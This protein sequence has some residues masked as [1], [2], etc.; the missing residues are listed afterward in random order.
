MGATDQ[1]H[2]DMTGKGRNELC[3]EQRKVWGRIFPDGCS[4]ALFAAL[5]KLI[6]RKY[7]DT[8]LLLVSLTAGQPLRLFGI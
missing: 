1:L 7:T 2:R 6:E 8:C 4:T 3:E 5:L